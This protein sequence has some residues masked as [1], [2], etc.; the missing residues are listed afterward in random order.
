M[1]RFRRAQPIDQAAIA[2]SQIVPGVAPLRIIVEGLA[3]E[4]VGQPVEHGCPEMI[5]LASSEN[6]Q[7]SFQKRAGQMIGPGLE[8]VQ[9]DQAAVLFLISPASKARQQ[10]ALA[11]PGFAPEHRPETAPFLVA[12]AG[13]RHQ[14]L[15]LLGMNIRHIDI[16]R[17]RAATAIVGEGIGC[18][19]AGKEG[20]QATLT[21]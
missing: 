6:A 3:H 1:P 12:F 7:H 5:D 20:F 4:T 17:R 9:I 16:A 15:E 18:S 11:D 13:Q 19:D 14:A 8:I 21:V 2:C 10:V